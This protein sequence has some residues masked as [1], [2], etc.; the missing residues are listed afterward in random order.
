MHALDIERLLHVK[1]VAAQLDVHPQTIRRA[2]DRGE[3]EAVR[4]GV[5]GRVA[6]EAVDAFLKPVRAGQS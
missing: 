1:Q 5:H 6:Q 4:L 3:L 2:I